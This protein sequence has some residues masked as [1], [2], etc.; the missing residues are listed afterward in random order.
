MRDERADV[1]LDRRAGVIV[2]LRD[3]RADVVE[4]ERTLQE[5]PYLRAHPVEPIA[6]PRVQVHEQ[7][8]VGEG[9]RLDATSLRESFA[10]ARHRDARI[11]RAAKLIKVVRVSPRLRILHIASFYAPTVGGMETVLQDLAEGLV[12]AGDEVTVLCSSEGLRGATESRSGVKVLRSP[13]LGKWFSQPMTPL[14]PVTLAR[15]ARSF[16][17]AHVHMPN[18]LAELAAALLPARLP[19]V[20]TYHADIIRQRL[21]WPL[22]AP[23][24]RMILARCRRIVVGTEQHIRYSG[25]LSPLRESC[26]VV[27]FGIGRQRYE[28][29]EAGRARAE[30]LRQRY[31]TFVLFVGRLVYYKGVPTLVESMRH[32]NGQLVIVG[33]GPMRPAVEEAIARHGLAS[34]VSLV[35]AVPQAELNAYLEAAAVLALPSFSRAENF[36]M[37]LLE[38]MLFGKP[39]VTSRLRSGVEAVNEEGQTGLIVEPRAPA[40]LAAALA[41]LLA[42]DGLRASMGAASRARLESH[43]SFDRMIAGYRAVYQEAVAR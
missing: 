19:V 12:A 7:G 38:G 40:D 26:T 36:G 9:P 11:S 3:R 39:L 16:D 17:I 8:A 23:T 13:S 43:F 32:V 41:R 15:L 42:D 1:A 30:E 14:L 28:L 2:L 34:R 5:R 37:I 10:G 25:V 22:F 31:G 20:A 6:A 24:R 18:P 33:E 29:G 27:P 35:G 4:D 21:L